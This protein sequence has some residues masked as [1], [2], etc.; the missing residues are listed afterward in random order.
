VLARP[1]RHHPGI[2]RHAAAT[3]ISE[4][5]AAVK[6][7]FPDDA[8]LA[9]RTGLCPGNHQSAGKRRSGKPRPP[10]PHRV[11]SALTT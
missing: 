11:S 9:S 4:I 6:E 3:V 7:I 8:H 2:G 10:G 5:G 1:A